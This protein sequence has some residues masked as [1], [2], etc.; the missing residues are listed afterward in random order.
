MYNRDT[1]LSPGFRCLIPHQIDQKASASASACAS[2]R[3]DSMLSSVS[4]AFYSTVVFIV[5]STV[6]SVELLLTA[7]IS[8]L[9][10]SRVSKGF[11]A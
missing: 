4:Y 9:I 7:T 2:A 1:F 3:M 6:G 10:C 8:S 11:V 5:S